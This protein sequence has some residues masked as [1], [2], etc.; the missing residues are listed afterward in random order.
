MY[1]TTT[2]TATYTVIDIRKTFEGFNADLRMIAARTE[3]LTMSEVENYIHDIMHLAE[4]KYL[5]WLDI[6]LTDA[7]DQPVRAVRFSIDE[8]G[9]ATQSQRAGSNDWENI[10]NTYLNVIIQYSASW[11]ALSIEQK[12]K[13]RMDNGFKLNWGPTSINTNY[14]HLTKQSA[15]LYA[16]NGYELKKDNY[17]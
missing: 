10:R 1:S 11:R 8:N 14:S 12:T 13:F 4:A 7:N 6:T 17:K 2:K 16:S 5:Q 15:Q 3:K 9:H